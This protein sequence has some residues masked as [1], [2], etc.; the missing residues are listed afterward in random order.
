MHDACPFCDLSDL[1]VVWSSELVIAIRDGYP[2]APG[3][4]LVIPR[5]HVASW[6]EATAAEQQEIWRAVGELKEALDAEFA[7]DGYNIGINAGEAAGQTVHSSQSGGEKALHEYGGRPSHPE[8]PEEQRSM[9][10]V[11]VAPMLS[12]AM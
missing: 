10:A 7:P 8:P 5:R 12:S 2:V 4:T 1:R 11:A 9:S 3:H 6:F